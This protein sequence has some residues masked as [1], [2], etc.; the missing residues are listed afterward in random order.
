MVPG[1][2]WN[3][4]PRLRW[5]VADVHFRSCLGRNNCV[6]DDY[7]CRACGRSHE[8]IAGLRTLATDVALFAERMGYDNYDDFLDYIAR[9]AAGKIRSVRPNH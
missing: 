1:N 8:E 4:Q 5:R 3:W 7:G 9:K 6:E 2:A